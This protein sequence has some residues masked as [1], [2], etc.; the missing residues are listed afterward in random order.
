MRI[1][2]KHLDVPDIDDMDVYIREGGYKALEKA[3]KEMSPDGVIQAVTKSG[4]RGRGGAGFPTGKK[5]AFIPKDPSLKKYLCCNADE[6][7][8]GTFK[9]RELIVRNP[10]QLIEGMAI[11]CYAIGSER[12][13]IYIRGE[14]IEPARK[15]EQAIAKASNR[16]FLGERILGTDFNLQIQVYRGA[17]A[18]ICG[19][20]SA[21]L[22]SLEGIRGEP[23]LRPPFPAIKG[24]YESPTVINNVE[25]LANV[26]HIVLNGGEWFASIGTEKSTG[27]KVVSMSGHVNNPGNYE[28]D[29]GTPVREIIFEHA[30]G[31]LGGKRLK[32]YVPGGSSVPML[33]EKHLDVGLDFESMLAAGSMLGSAGFMVMNEDTCIVRA[34]LNM[35]RFYAHES[36][37][38]CTPCREGTSWMVEML[39]SIEEGTGKMGYIDRL[40]DIANNINGRSFCALGDA[41][42]MPV[43]SSIEHFRDEYE[44]HVS[45]R[46][47]PFAGDRGFALRGG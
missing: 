30:G 9:D 38:K 36:C 16:G 12:A 42:A 32:A 7:E 23:R 29:M 41:S 22:N 24:L 8:P 39:E 46:G 43:L 33:T 3:L 14:Y 34:T 17:G 27:T 19:E 47:C 20:E 10:H 40:V 44:T 21:L 31:I 26:P 28:V 11:C 2:F 6:S 25:T 37:G 35:A 13:F 18:Y 5:W 1:L 45:E 15:M 4:L